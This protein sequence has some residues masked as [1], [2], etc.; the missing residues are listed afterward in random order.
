MQICD[1]RLRHFS[2]N[3]N[4][5]TTVLPSVFVFLVQVMAV[6]EGQDVTSCRPVESL[7]GISVFVLQ[8][9]DAGPSGRLLT[10]LC[11]NTLPRVIESTYN[12]MWIKFR[13]DTSNHGRGFFA[14][15]DTS[16]KQ[17]A[18]SASFYC[19]A[20]LSVDRSI[21]PSD[22][23]CGPEQYWTYF[24]ANLISIRQPIDKLKFWRRV[25]IQPPFV[26]LRLFFD[27]LIPRDDG[28]ICLAGRKQ[29]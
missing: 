1:L 2:K 4:F 10:K 25:F 15:Y 3:A 12:Q 22:G 19:L 13:T 23:L 27:H 29:N 20:S 11:G 24:E 28:H 5:G 26:N 17:R 18:V 9:R 8:I 14:T 7:D 16:K 21:D 6:A